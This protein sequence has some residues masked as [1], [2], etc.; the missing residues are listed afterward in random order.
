M[1]TRLWTNQERTT[2]VQ[3][4]T[5]SKPMVWIH[6]NIGWLACGNAPE[7]EKEAEQ[8]AQEI[9]NGWNLKEAS[10]EM[11]IYFLGE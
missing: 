8:F 5:D 3:F 4:R 1:K 9:A 2:L 7:D 11:A 6:T 10:H